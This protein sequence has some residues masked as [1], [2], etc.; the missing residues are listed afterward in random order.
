MRTIRYQ[1]IADIL[2]ARIAAVGAGQVLP[3]ESEL[4]AE[5]VVSRV[6]IRRAL[7]ILRDE[8]L[9]DARQGFGWYVSGEPVRQHLDELGTIEGQLERR[10]I[11]PERRVLEFAFRTAPKRVAAV[12]GTDQ[13]LRVKRLN[14]ADFEPFA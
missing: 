11:K 14:L 2:R 12:L 7:E 5:F 13:V 8:G 1:Q 3:S 4:S 6:T 10:G 9:V